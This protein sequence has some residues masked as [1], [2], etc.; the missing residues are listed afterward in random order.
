MESNGLVIVSSGCPN[1]KRFLD[2]MSRV[3]NHGFIISDYSAL[4]PVQKSNISAVPTVILNNG[5]RM[6]GTTAFTWLSETFS[7]SMEPSGF[8]GFENVDLSYS[9]IGDSVG[10]CK[11]QDGYAEL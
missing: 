5:A 10:Y 9:D 1:C 11:Y 4:T 6:V 7:N 2:S 3:K 8:G